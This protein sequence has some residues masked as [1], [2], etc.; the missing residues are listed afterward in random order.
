MERLYIHS[1]VVSLFWL[2][3]VEFDWY[4]TTSLIF[5]LLYPVLYYQ[6]KYVLTIITPL[7]VLIIQMFYTYDSSLLTLHEAVGLARLPMFC[8]GIYLQRSEKIS[9]NNYLFW[10]V[11]FGISTVIHLHF[12]YIVDM[13]APFLLICMY[14][15]IKNIDNKNML[16]MSL[17]WLGGYT[18]EIYIANML[19]Y[20]F[21]KNFLPSTIGIRVVIYIVGICILSLLLIQI[22]CGFNKMILTKNSRLK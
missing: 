13:G 1:Y 6:K 2:G 3:G 14:L 22:S 5:Y 20:V 7:A 4:L 15:V 8:W 10:F 19:I 21:I 12:F 18:L 11:L 17:E 16:R 9:V